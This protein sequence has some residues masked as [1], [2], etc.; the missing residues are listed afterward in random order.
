MAHIVLFTLL[1]LLLN[2]GLGA[3]FFGVNVLFEKLSRMGIARRYA[4]LPLRD[5]PESYHLTALRN[6]GALIFWISLMNILF[7]LLGIFRRFG[8]EFTLLDG[9]TPF[10]RSLAWCFANVLFLLMGILVRKKSALLRV[11]HAE[12]DNRFASAYNLFCKYNK[13]ISKVY[14]PEGMFSAK[15][16]LD[17]LAR[18]KQLPEGKLT[19]EQFHSLLAAYCDVA[20]SH[21]SEDQVARTLAEKYPNVVTDEIMAHRLIPVILQDILPVVGVHH[22]RPGGIRATAPIRSVQGGE[23]SLSQMMHSSALPP[24]LRRSLIFLKDGEFARADEYLERVLDQEPENAYA[25][26]AKTMAELKLGRAE[27]LRKYS[28]QLMESR[29]FIHALEYS[30]GQLHK[31]LEALV[32]NKTKP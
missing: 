28:G 12:Q 19:V 10:N 27:D 4:I 29:S 5:C 16:V 11:N 20:S 24:L 18:K 21:H 6:T 7:A 15:M 32:D 2:L 26:L 9:D 17:G 30:K 31:D 25:Y 8:G 13:A 1:G 22:S 14:F 3:V 23:V